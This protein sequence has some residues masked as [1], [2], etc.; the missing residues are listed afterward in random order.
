MS[1]VDK[2]FITTYLTADDSWCTGHGSDGGE[3]L[4]AGML[5]YALAYS[6]RSQTCVCLGSGGGFVPRLM[7]QAQRDLDLEGSR[8]ILVDGAPQVR[9]ERKEIWGS[10]DWL[11]EDSTFRRN[12][13]DVEIV[14]SLTRDAVEEYFVPNGVVIDYLHIDA[15][16]HYDG[17]KLDWDLYSPLVDGGGVITLHDT[18]NFR[19]PCGVPQLIEEI[20]QDRNYSLLDFPIKYGT[21]VVRKNPTAAEGR[22]A[23]V[24]RG[25]ARARLGPGKR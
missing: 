18:V 5:Y 13:P 1:L 17:V 2:N 11:A 22:S 20:R 6:L 3:D 15:D 10:P 19:E 4:G 14:L 7:R 24:E 23:G 25:T 8:T 16:H 21:A 12:Y 9:Q